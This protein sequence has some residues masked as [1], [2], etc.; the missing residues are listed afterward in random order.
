MQSNCIKKTD[1]AIQFIHIN[2]QSI[3]FDLCFVLGDYASVLPT[4]QLLIAHLSMSHSIQ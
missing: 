4:I 3:I 2:L 1:Y